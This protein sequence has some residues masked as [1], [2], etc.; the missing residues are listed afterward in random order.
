M[1]T[2]T[3]QPLIN[4]S[5]LRRD[6]LPTTEDDEAEYVDI[7]QLTIQEQIQEHHQHP[8]S[9]PPE[10]TRIVVPTEDDRKYHSI[11]RELEGLKSIVIQ[12]NTLLQTQNESITNNLDHSTQLND[13]LK[14][15]ND[16]IS[17]LKSQMQ[18]SRWRYL[19]DY[20][21]PLCSLM[22]LNMPVLLVF[23]LKTGLI[24]LPFSWLICKYL[25]YSWW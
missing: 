8:S 7:S 21:F 13:Q 22:G 24:S 19:R 23:G 5:G 25:T 12:M 11:L 14:A 18:P 15:L 1:N 2:L 16:Q 10:E 3:V 4:P 17:G 9:E 6:D 20:F